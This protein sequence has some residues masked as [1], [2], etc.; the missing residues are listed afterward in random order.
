MKHKAILELY[1]TV[2]VIRE[3]DD[4]NLTFFDGDDN[5]VSVTTDETAI[6]NKATELQNADNLKRLRME[7]NKMLIDTDYWDASDTP[8][9]SQGQIDYR[10]ALRDITNTYTSLDDVVWPTKPE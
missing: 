10:Q 5:P 1:S 2:K 7:R 4:G 8:T 3:D 9:M 6:N